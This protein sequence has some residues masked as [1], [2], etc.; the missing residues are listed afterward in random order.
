MPSPAGPNIATACYTS[1]L[2]HIGCT[3]YAHET[4]LVWIDDIAANRAARKTSFADPRDLFRVFLPMLT[5]GMS[6]SQRARIAA[7]FPTKGP[8]FGKRFTTATCEVATQTARRLGL[9]EGVQRGLHEVFEWW[10]GKGAPQAL[11]GEDIAVAGRVAHVAGTAAEN[12]AFGGPE[13]AVEAI[14][15]RAG[16][17]LDPSIADAFV[18]RGG[19]LLEAATSGDPR[20]LMLGAEPEPVRVVSGAELPDVAAI[21]GDIADL[22]TPFT[23]GHSAG[24]AG[25]ARAAGDKLALDRDGL[26]RL[27][28]AS[29][30]HDLGRIGVPDFIWEKPGELTSADWEQVRLHPH[31]SERILSFSP[32]LQ[33]MATIAGMHHERMDGSGYHRGCRAA[34]IPVSA[35]I[36]AAADALQAMTQS[37]PHRDPL[38]VDEAAERIQRDAGA[39][40][41]DPDA[42]AAVVEVAGGSPKKKATFRPG[43]LSDRE[44]EVLNLM[45]QGPS[46]RATSKG[47]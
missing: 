40:R 4:Y 14:R 29:L 21:F 32:V 27:H 18:A 43:G 26:L 30:L 22:K 2:Q 17:I 33:P 44:V 10:N 39:G 38:T 41:F 37:R 11:K 1:L 8:G 5:H 9:P 34:E 25:L 12:E 36:L 15:R 47:S 46:G 35:R 23:H 7:H 20:R 6:V 42:V 13:L 19:E 28:V 31:H 16:V 3:G 45:A 24:V